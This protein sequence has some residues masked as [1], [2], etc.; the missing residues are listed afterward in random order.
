MPVDTVAAYPPFNTRFEPESLGPSSSAFHEAF[1]FISSA[2]TT[3]FYPVPFSLTAVFSRS[4]VYVSERERESTSSVSDRHDSYVF[5][6]FVF[7]LANS[8]LLYSFLKL[9]PRF[10]SMICFS[11]CLF[12]SFSFHLFLL[13][14][15]SYDFL[16]S[17][18]FSFFAL[19]PFTHSLHPF[20]SPSP[21][22]TPPV[23][24]L[25]SSLP[26]YHSDL[27]PFSF[28][29]NNSLPPFV[30]ALFLCLLGSVMKS[31]FSKGRTRTILRVIFLSPSRLSVRVPQWTPKTLKGVDCDPFTFFVFVMLQ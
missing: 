12:F 1:F 9:F 7:S 5:L 17:F 10:V 20:L 3:R 24:F 4:S 16:S 31:S 30:F 6:S 27:P 25:S 15:F 13:S 14:S 11:L 29:Y 26:F 8:V 22:S 18:H 2:K 28:F 23:L 21:S 19:P